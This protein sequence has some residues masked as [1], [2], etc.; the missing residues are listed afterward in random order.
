MNIRKA[1]GQRAFTLIE[2]LV[3]IAIIAILAALLLPALAAAKQAAIVTKCMSNKKQMDI[4]WVMYAG[5]NREVLA[6]DHDYVLPDG[7]G[8][9]EPGTQ[10]PCWAEGVLDFTTTTQNTNNLYLINNELSLLGSYVGNQVAIFRCP[11]DTYVSS[12]QRA[13][14]F[15]FRNRS[16]TMNAAV[17]PGDQP[18]GPTAMPNGKYV[19]FSW[20]A[21]YFVFVSKMSGFIHPGAA[22]TWVFMDE[23]PDSID[24]TLLY[25]DD[26]PSALQTGTGQF[27]ELPASY[28]NRACGLAFADGHAE[29]HKW[30]NAQTMPPIVT[31]NVNESLYRQVPVTS[32]PDLQ[33]LAQKT[34]RPIGDD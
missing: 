30:Q 6:D 23:H 4:A 16:I 11:A 31:E 19:G 28:H 7:L 34:Q 3:V 9:W 27:T 20:S 21:N 32:D 22:D 18:N 29:I 2:L 24:D 8:P 10:T 25:T 13:A 26:E 33:W 12:A 15:Q 5:E 1:P 17:G 14:G